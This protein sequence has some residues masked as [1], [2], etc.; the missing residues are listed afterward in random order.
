MPKRAWHFYFFKK[1]PW[2]LKNAKFAFFGLKMPSWQ[3]WW[4]QSLLHFDCLGVKEKSLVS[5]TVTVTVT[6]RKENVSLLAGMIM[7][8]P[9]EEEA[10]LE[11]R[12]RRLHEKFVSGNLGSSPWEVAAAGAPL[13]LSL[14][15]FVLASI[16][17]SLSP[18]KS[19]ALFYSGFRAVEFS[20]LTLPLLF[21][22]TCCSDPPYSWGMAAAMAA[23]AAALWLIV[24]GRSK[25]GAAMRSSGRLAHE[26]VSDR[27]QLPFVTNYRSAMLLTTAVCILAVDFP[28]FPRRHAK[29]ENFGYGLMDIGVGSF[30]FAAGLVSQ[31]AR[32]GTAGASAVSYLSKSLMEALPMLA[33]GLARLLSVK[34]S[35][36]HE[37]VT[38]YGLHWNFFFTLAFSK[39]A[40]SFFFALFPVSVSWPCALLLSLCHEACLSVGL[41][42]WVLSEDTP[43]DSLI[44]ANREG[45]CSVPGYVAIYLAGVAW[46]TKFARLGETFADSLAEAKSLGMT[47]AA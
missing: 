10:D 23:A 8:P 30:V 43:R 18:S 14:L 26:R 41:A 34:G 4:Q 40:T 39:V 42:D 47:M 3:P 45:L 25:K 16:A 44:S 21:G 11:Q 24:T 46:G 13:N 6:L 36:Y 35:G 9:E 32:R 38:E 1:M 33:L 37:H 31:E 22:L 28:V 20:L 12:Y 2:G 27:R 17:T 7:S 15:L 19:S 29:T 5:L